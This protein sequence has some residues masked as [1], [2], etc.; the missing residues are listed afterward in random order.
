MGRRS[1]A[2]AL[3]LCPCE[4]VHLL[5]ISVD[6][7]DLNA[8][9]SQIPNRAARVAPSAVAAT[10]AGDDFFPS[11][12]PSGVRLE[13]R[14][15]RGLVL[16]A[17]QAFAAGEI[18]LQEAPLAALPP[19]DPAVRWAAG[20]GSQS[21][22]HSQ[23]QSHRGGWSVVESLV[24]SLGYADDALVLYRAVLLYYLLFLTAE[25]RAQPDRSHRAA[26]TI[27]ALH[28]PAREDPDQ[29]AQHTGQDNGDDDGDD[30]AVE[31]ST[32]PMSAPRAN[33]RA[34]AVQRRARRVSQQA[35]LAE[36]LRSAAGR[37]ALTELFACV[38]AQAARSMGVVPVEVSVSAGGD[39][40]WDEA[41]F[42]SHALPLADVYNINNMDCSA[43]L[44]PSSAPAAAG[45]AAAADCSGDAACTAIYDAL[46][47]LNHSCLPRCVHFLEAH[48]TQ[49]WSPVFGAAL[50][51]QKLATA[52]VAASADATVGATATVAAT[53][54]GASSPPSAPLVRTLRALCAIAPGDEL[55]ISYLSPQ[56]LCQSTRQR[57]AQLRQH[58]HF[59]CRCAR[60]DALDTARVMRCPS[61]DSGSVLVRPEPA[62]SASSAG[63]SGA[64]VG[65][66]DDG[67]DSEPAFTLVSTCACAAP[68][69][70]AASA[71]LRGEAGVEEEWARFQS[72]L[73]TCTQPVQL[74]ALFA[75]LL[76]RNRVGDSHWLAFEFCLVQRDLHA[77]MR[78]PLDQME[79]LKRAVWFLERIFGRAVATDA[80]RLPRRYFEYRQDSL[81]IDCE[82]P[83]FVAP[84][85]RVDGVA[86]CTELLDAWS[87]L[88]EVLWSI[89]PDKTADL[90][91][92]LVQRSVYFTLCAVRAARALTPLRS[93]VRAALDNKLRQR[94]AVA[95]AKLV[96]LS[97]LVEDTPDAVLPAAPM[98]AAA[99]ASAAPVALRCH[100]PVCP[101]NS[102]SAAP[103]VAALI[104]TR[105]RSVRYCSA[106]CQ[107]VDWK[108]HKPTCKAAK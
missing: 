107:R 73:P 82:S 89:H 85:A 23:S 90:Q 58:W 49:Q 81:L 92:M 71:L 10:A 36:S 86:V 64:D 8:M 108:L 97:R 19:F 48:Q 102:F 99:S 11:P 29:R 47:R 91:R 16:L 70:A 75:T 53:T 74:S 17:S 88:A 40:R 106:A 31:I 45:V 56:L 34:A 96:D 20:V 95:R 78:R 5:S 12:L 94:V 105:C 68:E 22:P 13:R 6:P 104:C 9:S 27:T 32:T 67:D 72:S 76:S 37:A 2:A 79:Q 30:D 42:L 28:D 50:T 69:G 1:I 66:V 63:G 80:A 38:A 26:Q 4:C 33:P 52:S 57:Q 21:H 14:A 61:C 101:S 3:I 59:T 60:C 103:P 39:D 43:A 41:H 54:A 87:E 7:L 24:R 18:I 35:A 51:P 100:S 77:L 46:S 15:G 44:A 62:A 65:L 93:P 84:S 98:A 25:G 55:T 83:A